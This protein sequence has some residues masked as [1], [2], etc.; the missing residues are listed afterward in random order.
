LARESV[1]LA[2]ALRNPW[3]AVRGLYRRELAPRT[4]VFRSGA[5]L[6]STERD[7]L[8]FLIQEIILERH[9]TPRWFYRRGENDVILDIG[10]N[11]GVFAIHVCSLGREN[12]VHCFEPDP[13]SFATLQ[14]N[15]AASKLG[16]RVRVYNFAV[17][18]EPGSGSLLLSD[19]E[20]SIV[21][22]F[23]PQTT[24]TTAAVPCVSLA[25]AITLACRPDERVALLKIDAEGAEAEILSGC[26]PVVWKRVQRVALEY[27]S[28]ELRDQCIAILKSVGF[29]TYNA[30]RGPVGICLATQT[31]SDH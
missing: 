27:H 12:R 29:S 21:Q 9:Y 14:A 22:Q 25:Q 20:K 4:V 11:I 1:Q 19:Q 8:Q 17:W 24:A 3:A 10:A 31:G 5:R 26:E 18:S 23:R 16:H 30:V 2:I 7:S 13:Q 15:I 6:G 28:A